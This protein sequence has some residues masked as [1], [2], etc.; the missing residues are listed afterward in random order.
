MGQRRLT[1]RLHFPG[2]LSLR[3]A[4]PPFSPD[5]VWLEGPPKKPLERQLTGLLPLLAYLQP[6]D[7][8]AH[9]SPQTKPSGTSWVV[10]GG[11]GMSFLVFI[12][13]PDKKAFQRD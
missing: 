11:D 2:A 13:V 6:R 4:L 7:E 12:S 3:Q 5:P 10:E 1:T 8:P 9:L